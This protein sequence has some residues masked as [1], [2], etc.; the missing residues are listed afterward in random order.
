MDHPPR[1]DLNSSREVADTTLGGSWFQS[2]TVLG[3]SERT[4]S[5]SC[6]LGFSPGR[7]YVD[8]VCV[9]HCCVDISLLVNRLSRVEFCTTL[10][11]CLSSLS[12]RKLVTTNKPVAF[13]SVGT[14][15]E[16]PFLLKKYFAITACMTRGFTSRKY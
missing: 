10:K 13:R 2:L 6:H 15:I 16:P 12:H 5:C 3:I 14:G 7:I 11:A 8:L 4:S 9:S 1:S